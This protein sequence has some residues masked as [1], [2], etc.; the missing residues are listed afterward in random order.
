L[1]EAVAVLETLRPRTAA[2]AVEIQLRM[3]EDWHRLA[4]YGHYRES[5]EAKEGLSGDEY[6]DRM[7][8]RATACFAAAAAQA[9]TDAGLRQTV[10]D[11]L[12]AARRHAEA[13]RLAPATPP[14]TAPAPGPAAVRGTATLTGRIELPDGQPAAAATVT[15]G[16]HVEVAEDDPSNYLRPEMHYLPRIGEQRALTAV[17]DRDGAFRL[18]AVPAGRHEFL[19][20]TLDENRFDIHTRFLLHGIRVRAGARLELGRLT[21]REWSS[22][23]AAPSGLAMPDTVVR[24]AVRC[25]AVHSLPLSNPFHFHFPRQWLTLPA[26]A[27]VPPDRLLLLDAAA[28]DTPIPIQCTD[29]GVGFFAELPPLSTRLL[30]LYVA[31]SAI[32]DPEPGFADLALEPEPGGRTAVINT[33]RAAFR[34]PLGDRPREGGN[35]GA[36]GAARAPEDNP[37]EPGPLL[38]VRGED[39][40]W[41]GEGRLVLP[42]HVRVVQRRT[43][44]LTAGPLCLR[45]RVAYALSTGAEYAVTFTAHRGEPCLLAHEVSPP[46]AGAAFE[47]SLREFSGGRGYLHWTP[48]NGN[49]HWSDLAADDRELARLQESVAWWIP[50]Q[51]FAYAMTA[52]TLDSNDYIGVFTVRRGDWTDREFDR[53]TRGPINP[54]GSPN[55]ELDWPYPEMV[56]STLSMITAHTRADGD[57]LFRFRLFDGERH[58]GVLA[59]NLERND[60]P[61]KEISSVQ[62]KNSSPQLQEFKDWHLDEP[63]AVSRPH[64]VARREDLRRLR[65][66]RV[67][68]AFRQVWERL[69]AG[70]AGGAAAGLKA[71]LDGDPLTLWRR[72]RELAGVAHI[73]ARMTLL[74]R[75]FADM[76]SPVGARPITPWAEE[77]DLIA[78]TGAF[79]PDEE[80][81]TRAFLILMGHLYMSPD[82]MNWKFGSRNCNFEADRTDVVGAVGLCFHGHPDA[83][84]MLHHVVELME[85]SI[86]TYSTPGSGKWYE[87]PACYYLQAAKCRCNLAFHL[88]THGVCDVT[89]LP[90]FREF[91]RWGILLLTPPCPSDEA[92]MRDGLTAR[93]YAAATKVRR[94][95]PVGDHARLGPW[96][97]EHYALM[98]RLYRQAGDD[99]FA[100]ELLGAYQSGGAD[101]GYFGNLPLLFARLEDADMRP[102]PPLRL[103]SRRLEGFGAILRGNVHRDN[104]FCLLLK[105]GPGGYRYHRTEG[106]FILFAHGRPLV[107]DGGEAGETWRHSTLS[108]HDSHMPLAPGHVTAFHSDETMDFVQGVHPAALAPGDAV[109]FS[110]RCD[111]ELVPLAWQRF[112]ETEPADVRTVLWVKDEYVIVHDDLALP[113]GVSTHWHLQVLAHDE[114]HAGDGW[115]FRG[116]FGTDLQVVLP[117]QSFTAARVESQ[118]MLE[119]HAPAGGPVAM[120]H[121]RLDATSPAGVLAVLRPLAP[122]KAPL[123]VTAIR[124]DG[125]LIGC[126]IAGDGLDDTILLTRRT[127]TWASDGI[128][129][130][131]RAAAILRRPD[132]PRARLLAGQSLEVTPAGGPGPVAA[133]I[134]PT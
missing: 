109:F 47:F 113:P 65:A 18:E 64:L 131:G 101:G 94:L 36:A 105:Q 74:G 99:A 53:L 3:A 115:R 75:D 25:R 31:D 103:A 20:V 22:A 59:S 110:D 8:T 61:C 72:K 125:R 39:G 49:R 27:G 32:A 44:V 69:G 28:P 77:Y 46:L 13:D 97:P 26:P 16:L 130:H 123:E 67:A 62:H 95:P 73:R 12:R 41:R 119:Y 92:A 124:H 107:Y 91:L 7:E 122:G 33:G 87:N 96:V 63:D 86:N 106:S 85:R 78:P 129:F 35:S 1:R 116:R 79:T 23:P 15:L 127:T 60:G 9:G 114:M 24:R 21:A 93:D 43:E 132:G 71:I 70:H 17:T 126:R 6:A 38:A 120:R 117:G 48:E 76:Y 34:L 111:H 118:P 29:E 10:A 89:R 52:G 30:R 54:D 82:L 14:P 83:A 4:E 5:R 42:A 19:A 58:W 102:A 104:E 50:P 98:A 37:H 84:A 55:H 133:R 112:A 51:G 134:E 80:R 57:A 45:V 81:L 128:H 108:F 100:D 56:G 121:L 68:P 40:V 66:R 88:A 11:A 2:E 90:R